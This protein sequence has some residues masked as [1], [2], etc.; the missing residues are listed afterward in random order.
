MTGPA[1]PPFQHLMAFG[2]SDQASFRDPRVRSCFDIMTVPGTIASYYDEA[3]A[4]FV[5]SSKV[6]YLI[7]PRTPLFQDD[8]AA[9][10]ASHFSLAEWHG[11]SVLSRLPPAGPARFPAS[12]FTPAVVA[13]MV[14]EVVGRQRGYAGNAPRVTKKLDRYAQLLAQAM[15]QQ[16]AQVPPGGPFGPVAV[17]APYFAVTGPNDPWFAVLQEVWAQCA[18]LSDSRK[19]SPVLCVGPRQEA[20]PFGTV[21]V[22]G[23]AVLG[24][25]LATLPPALGER[26]YV[27]ITGFDERAVDEGQLRRLWRTVRAQPSGRELVNLYGG[28]FSACLW[29]AGLSGFGNGLTYSESRAWP[30]LASTGSAPPRYYLRDLHLFLPPAAAQ[31]VIAAEPSFECPCG[32]CAE[33]RA[34]GQTI[35]S[36]PYHSLKRHFAHAR[37]WELDQV[38]NGPATAVAARL[39]DAKRRLDAVRSSLPKGI[40]PQ[41]QHLTN[42]ANVLLNP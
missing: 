9:P 15:Q 37:Q 32:A 35:A 12:F 20:G 34:L 41:A 24:E 19:I 8:L 10:R 39:T 33:I 16:H 28:F 23:V 1:L 14:A 25:L 17:L 26:C 29:Y 42:W 2:N 40:S 11:P 4:A 36:M 7:D 38:A 30:A 27:W 5:L 18:A 13:E 3:T 6:P 22:D 31:A 21:T